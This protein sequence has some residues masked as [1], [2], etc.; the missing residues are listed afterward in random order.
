MHCLFKVQLLLVQTDSERLILPWSENRNL[1][2]H[3]SKHRETKKLATPTAAVSGRG[4]ASGHFEKYSVAVTMNLLPQMAS[5]D[6][7]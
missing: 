6:Q 4:A 3:D 1:A 2:I 5:Q 7:H